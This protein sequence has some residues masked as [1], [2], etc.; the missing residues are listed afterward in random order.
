MKRTLSTAVLFLILVALISNQ[1]VAATTNPDDVVRD[2][3]GWYVGRLAKDDS[4]PL[5][6]RSVALKFLTP[7]FIGRIPALLKKTDADPII[8]AQDFDP[9]WAKNVKIEPPSING[10]V[11]TT[12]V[13]LVG[14]HEMQVKLKVSLKKTAAGWRIDNIDCGY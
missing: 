10:N 2:F 7:K 11:A 6:N 3:Y 1:Q 13:E 14:E 12:N 4:K 9:A 8:C 5:K